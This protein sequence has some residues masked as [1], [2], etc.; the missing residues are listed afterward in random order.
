MFIVKRCWGAQKVRV[1]EQ[2]KLV[3]S[4]I[5]SFSAYESS[6]ASV[7]EELAAAAA[8]TNQQQVAAEQEQLKVR[9]RLLAA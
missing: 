6:T 7:A 3:E 8:L 9:L 2:A 5:A 1:I 4:S